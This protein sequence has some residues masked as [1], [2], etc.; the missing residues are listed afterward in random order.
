MMHKV[1]GYI[2]KGKQ[3]GAT[4]MTGGKRVGNS[5]YYIEPTVFANVTDDMTI[6]KEEVIKTN[7]VRFEV[8]A[9]IIYNCYFRYSDL[10]RA[11]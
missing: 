8:V 4:L 10:C 2:E 3:E 9:V 6:S 5:G 1:L 7:K 11:S